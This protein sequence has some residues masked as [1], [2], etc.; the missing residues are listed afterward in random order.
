MKWFTGYC[1]ID[2]ENL[3]WCE[4][5]EIY[6]DTYSQHSDD[7]LPGFNGVI[8][9]AGLVFIF[10]S[11]S[12]FV[13]NCFGIELECVLSEFSLNAYVQN[14]LYNEGTQKENKKL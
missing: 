11:I 10:I 13:V 5:N 7:P 9:P 3:C 1:V 2:Q 4:T 6:H 12:V 14:Y 8:A